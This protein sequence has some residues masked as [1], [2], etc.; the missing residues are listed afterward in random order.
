MGY[1]QAIE[2]AGCRV[3]AFGEFGTWS[4]DWWARVDLQGKQHWV[5]GYYGS[6]S[7]CDA[8]EGEFGWEFHDE[9]INKEWIEIGD[10][11]H[12]RY[13]EY[14][15]KLIVFGLSYLDNLKTQEEAEAA[16]SRDDSWDV[17]AGAVLAFIKA[18]AI[19]EEQPDV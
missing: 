4:G 9:E 8:F 15:E 18:N 19:E 5:S 10:P 6:C 3:L 2:A 11:R 13:T 1:K 14:Q 17:E 16:S 7:G 12:S